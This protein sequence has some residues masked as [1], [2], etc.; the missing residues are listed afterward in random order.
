VAR[1]R[2]GR[3]QPTDT[4]TACLMRGD[5][6]ILM[7]RAPIGLAIFNGY[8]IVVAGLADM[9]ADDPR[10]VVELDNR[11]SVVSDVDVVLADMFA[12]VPGDGTGLE[13]IIA[14][15]AAKLVV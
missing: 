14:S 10:V 11:S 15:C 9:L 1:R 13:D 12:H 6:R 2:L 3:A 4:Q 8:E 7:S 5:L